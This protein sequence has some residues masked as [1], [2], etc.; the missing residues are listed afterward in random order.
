MENIQNDIDN[1]PEGFEFRDEY[2]IQG[3]EI[4]EKMKND[5][6]RKKRLIIFFL[7]FSLSSILALFY[8]SFNSNDSSRNTFISKTKEPTTQQLTNEKN[9]I[10]KNKDT[11]NINLF[12]STNQ[13][14]I[15]QQ[16]SNKSIISI[17]NS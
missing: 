12:N 11:E 5:Q 3:F 14:R 7:G 16:I 6:K 13:S 10:S 17:K 1:I 9:L 15:E 2:M 8:V 4:Y